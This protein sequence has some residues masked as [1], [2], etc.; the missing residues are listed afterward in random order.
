MQ[1]SLSL[2]PYLLLPSADS[3]LLN[4]EIFFATGCVVR[5]F[6]RRRRCR[7]KPVPPIV[8]R[9]EFVPKEKGQKQIHEHA[10]SCYH[11]T[12]G[13]NVHV[14]SIPF[15]ATFQSGKFFPPLSRCCHG[16]LK[17]GNLT[18]DRQKTFLRGKVSDLFPCQFIRAGF[19]IPPIQ[20]HDE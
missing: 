20:L 10:G 9:L 14:Y 13:L 7:Q 17:G 16:Y 15:A 19:E 5:S 1:L 2:P 4:R 6:F 8:L 12:F 3:V 11:R 18:W